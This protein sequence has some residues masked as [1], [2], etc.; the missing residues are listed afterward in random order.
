MTQKVKFGLTL[1]NRGVLLGLTQ[2]EEILEMAELAD[3]SGVRSRLGWRLDNGQASHGINYPDVG[4]RCS[5]QAGEDRRRMHGQFPFQGA[6]YPG[7]PMGQH[8]PAVQW[9]YDFGCLHGRQHR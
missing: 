5:D 7:I 1:S 4:H 9:S 8:G 2:P 3:S 6:H